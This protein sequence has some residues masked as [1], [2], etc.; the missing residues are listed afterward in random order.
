MK[1][2]SF[3]L[4]FVLWLFSCD[5]EVKKELVIKPFDVSLK[6]RDFPEQRSDVY[7]VFLKNVDTNDS[8]GTDIFMPDNRIAIRLYPGVYNIYCY[9]LVD[10]TQ[11]S[12]KVFSYRILKNIGIYESQELNIDLST[13]VPDFSISGQTQGYLL[14]V[15]MNEIYDIFSVSSLSVKQG[16]GRAVSIDYQLDKENLFYYSPIE[17]IKSGSW[18]M[19]ISYSLKSKV[20]DKVL[21]RDN[22]NISTSNF[23]DIYL[24]DFQ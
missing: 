11:T 2:F 8:S 20:D 9:G 12:K 18:F 14:K 16:T 5:S 6:L 1:R 3:I 7:H 15:F 22:I 19:N 4:I 13:L 17:L 10:K 21:K 24:G 23:T